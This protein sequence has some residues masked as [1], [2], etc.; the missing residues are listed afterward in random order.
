VSNATARSDLVRGVL[1]AIGAGLCWGGAFVAP[2]VLPG[3]SALELT[4]GRFAGSGLFSLVMLGGAM[5]S[6]HAAGVG[7]AGLWAT[8][9]G[10]AMVGNFLYFV[11]MIAG[12]QR[13]NA[14]IVTLIIGLLPV[15]LP[16][17]AEVRAGTF[18]V[19]RTILPAAMIFAGL[20]AVHFGAHGAGGDGAIDSRYLSGLAC[21]VFA[22]VAWLAFAIANTRAM[23]RRPELSAATWSSMQGVSL[24]PVALPLLAVSMMAG[25]THGG[26]AGRASLEMFLAVSMALGIVTS[27]VAMWCWN[28][29][30]QLL[31]AA[32]AGQLLVVETLASLAYIYLWTGA[33]P[34]LLV[35]AGAALL[36]AGVVVGVRMLRRE[37][38][39]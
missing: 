31:P 24:L 39:N 28:R 8:A 10:L 7:R 21:A 14:P 25:A 27:W 18:S 9:F 20:L 30:S 15:A 6:G 12:I 13:A 17:F 33:W 34:P 4:A 22:L 5:I 38:V 26:G 37:A 29:A 1:W 35:A 19:R 36:I 3:Y 11:A 23:A 2:L 32:L 16:I